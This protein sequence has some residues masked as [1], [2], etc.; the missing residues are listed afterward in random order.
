[1]RSSTPPLAVGVCTACALPVICVQE[2]IADLFV[3]LLKKKSQE[4][5]VGLGGDGK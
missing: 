3:A 5:V 1:M 4:L 2:S